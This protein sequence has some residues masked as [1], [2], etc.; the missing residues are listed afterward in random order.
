MTTEEQ[1]D[2][3]AFCGLV[4]QLTLQVN[5]LCMAGNMAEAGATALLLCSEQAKFK[6]RIL[7][8]PEPA[9]VDIDDDRL[10]LSALNRAFGGEPDAR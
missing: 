2:V 7:G 9:E 8:Q 1:A 3:L 5:R 10:S 6:R 4:R